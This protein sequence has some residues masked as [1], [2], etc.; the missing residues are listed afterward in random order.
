MKDSQATQIFCNS[1]YEALEVML[2]YQE[3]LQE[4]VF[5]STFVKLFDDLFDHLNTVSVKHCGPKQ[6]VT[7]L[8][9]D[10]LFS[11]QL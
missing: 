7:P 6:A 5:T 3:F 9:L 2:H 8:T 11:S 10:D 1:V 4:A